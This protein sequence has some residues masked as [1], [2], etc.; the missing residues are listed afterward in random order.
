MQAWGKGGLILC[1]A[2]VLWGSDVAWR[3]RQARSHGVKIDYEMTQAIAIDAKFDSGEPMAN[4]QVTVYAPED[5]TEPWLQ[6]TTDNQG[7]FIFAPD[8]AQ[9]GNWAV[10]VRHAGHGNLLNIA[11]APPAEADAGAQ[12]PETP[13]IA[14]QAVKG[15]TGMTPLQTGLTIASGIWGFVGTALFFSRRRHHPGVTPANEE[16]SAE[17]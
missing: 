17:N 15:S 3:A 10:R 4:A 2:C 9:S 7:R 11:I 14:P 5:P 13:A 8:P 6:G 1:C 12:E 16:L